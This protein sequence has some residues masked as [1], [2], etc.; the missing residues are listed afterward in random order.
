MKDDWVYHRGDVYVV[1]LGSYRGSIQGGKRPA[2]VMQNDV[3]NFYSDTMEV[4]P[5]T[6]SIK[7]E[8][9]ET[10]FMLKDVPFLQKDSMGI[11]EQPQP[12]NKNQILKFLGRLNTEQICE[13][14]RALMVEFGISHI[15]ECTEAP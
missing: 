9:Q 6:S 2:V 7:K 15:P 10:H 12:V 1:D 5:L 8:K 4:V 13:V 14:E 11:G 3:G